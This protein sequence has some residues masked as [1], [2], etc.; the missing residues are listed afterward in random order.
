MFPPNK[1]FIVAYRLS[2]A[3]ENCRKGNSKILKFSFYIKV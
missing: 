1:D 2:S 3:A